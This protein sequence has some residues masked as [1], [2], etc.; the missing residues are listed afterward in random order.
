[1][2]TV[3]LYWESYAPLLNAALYTQHSDSLHVLKHTD[4]QYLFSEAS[5]GRVIRTSHGNFIISPS[6]KTFVCE[7]IHNTAVY[8]GIIKLL[9]CNEYP[10]KSTQSSINF[11]LFGLI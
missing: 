7:H 11:N 5:F 4:I 3:Y 10:L 2:C 6:V 8:T 1:M 9:K